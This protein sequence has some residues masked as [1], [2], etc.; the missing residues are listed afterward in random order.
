M[1]PELNER[2]NYSLPQS[3]CNYSGLSLDKCLSIVKEVQGRL[4]PCKSS[5]LPQMMLSIRLQTP[6]KYF[7][8]I[9][10]LSTR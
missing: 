6:Q 8:H 7:S 4:T 5:S 9:F 10:H 2:T 3:K 1:F